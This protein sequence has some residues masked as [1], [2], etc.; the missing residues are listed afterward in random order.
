[1][2]V[3][4]NRTGAGPIIIAD[5]ID[6]QLYSLNVDGNRLDEIPVT[7]NTLS[8]PSSIDVDQFGNIFIADKLTHQILVVYSNG[9][10]IPLAGTY[11]VPG[12]PSNGI[13]S[14]VQFHTPSGLALGKMKETLFVADTD[15]HVIRKIIF[16]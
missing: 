16:Q 14:T 6:K 1:M 13:G 2:K 8:S 10:M 5:L 3:S 12:P 15:N 4:R 11:N 9:Q 7:G